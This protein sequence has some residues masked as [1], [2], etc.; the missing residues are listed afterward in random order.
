M[1]KAF[2][3]Y[4]FFVSFCCAVFF[5]LYGLSGFTIGWMSFVILAVYFGMGSKVKDV[6][7]IFLSII[8]GLIWG[9]LNFL[10]IGL[11]GAMGLSEAVGMFIS[12]VVMTTV[13]MGLH[14]TV[15]GKTPVN[16]VPFIFAGVALTFSQGGTNEIALVVTLIGGL[17]LAF[18]CSLGEDYIFL[19]FAEQPIAA[20]EEKLENQMT[21][22]AT[23]N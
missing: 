9:Q 13:T 4:S 5:F 6:P 20:A 1:K 10:F 3:L 8:A 11:L 22:D 16:R 15:L 21:G 7:A 2:W 19:H 17:L 18:V 12:I 14:L 23:E